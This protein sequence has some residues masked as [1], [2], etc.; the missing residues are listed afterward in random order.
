MII[1]VVIA[2]QAIANN[3]EKKNR[4][5]NGIRT[6]GLYD[7]AAVLYQLG[8]EDPY[9][10]RRRSFFFSGYRKSPIK[11]PFSAEQS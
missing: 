8:Y 10:E 3:P 11:P 7:S 2:I 5:F 6:Y 9:T 4:D 1:A